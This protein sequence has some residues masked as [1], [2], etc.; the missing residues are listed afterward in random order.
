MTTVRLESIGCRLNTS[1]MESLARQ[2]AACGHRVVGPGQP[3][4]VCVFNTCT[5]T[6]IASRKSR[7]VVHQLK[8]ANPDARIVV[9]GCYAEMEPERLRDLGLDLVVGN[10]D[11]DRL[12]E[13]LDD[14]GLIEAGEPDGAGSP[15]PF[16]GTGRTRAFVK[17]QDGC[18]NRCTFCVVT[19]ARG[20]GISRTDDDVLREMRDLVGAGY[21]EAVLSGVH[22]GSYGHDRGEPRALGRL[23]RRILDETPLE[24]LRLSSLEPWDL[25]NGFFDLFEDPRLLPH[26]HLPLQSGCDATL[27]RMA[28]RTS[29]AEFANLVAAARDRVPGIAIS[30]DVIVGFPG[31]TDDEFQQSLAY[32]RQQAFSRLH[33][34]R[35]S[36]RQ[37]TRAAAMPGQVAGPEA[38]RRGQAM[39]A[40]GAELEKSFA[41][42]SV[43]HTRPV[44][45]ETAEDRGPDRRWSGLTDHYVRVETQV[46]AETDLTNQI[47]RTR[48]VATLPGGL[49]GEIAEGDVATRGAP[50]PGRLPVLNPGGRAPAT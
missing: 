49:L 16:A 32:V 29:Q 17:V 1:E 43:G 6:A 37:G 18:D 38:A 4:D 12:I 44:L 27:H 22:L 33:V 10:A 28:R 3:A 2:L 7:Q 42:R 34:F 8:R 11:K 39:Q 47:T 46:P 26:L 15:G 36:A 9:T 45:W 35:F 24:R 14:A 23:V 25:D 40:L 30:T 5:V 41:A 48:L 20:S 21:R 31:E 50:A 13:L 19:L